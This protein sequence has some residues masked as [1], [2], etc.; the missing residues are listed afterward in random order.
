MHLCMSKSSP[1][2]SMSVSFSRPFQFRADTQSSRFARKVL[3]IQVPVNFLFPK[4][5][6]PLTS[7]TFTVLT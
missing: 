7:L 5:K 1:Q 4:W 6:S 3:L 2:G